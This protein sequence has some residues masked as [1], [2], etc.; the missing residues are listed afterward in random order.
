[1]VAHL[2]R[3][4]DSV[5]R[6][7]EAL[8][9]ALQLR[10]ADHPPR[11]LCEV[12]FRR[13]GAVEIHGAIHLRGVLNGHTTHQTTITIISTTRKNAKLAQLEI[14]DWSRQSYSKTLL[15]PTSWRQHINPTSGTIAT[16]TESYQSPVRYAHEGFSRLGFIENFM[17]HLQRQVWRLAHP[18]YVNA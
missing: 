13:G 8:E 15:T 17:Q 2:L 3:L 18:V 14:R 10:G 1:V 7:G 4:I 11:G 6:V 5:V 12:L 16:D 9:V